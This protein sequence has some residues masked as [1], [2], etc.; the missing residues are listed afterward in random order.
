MDQIL[1]AEQGMAGSPR[2]RPSRRHRDRHIVHFLKSEMDFNAEGLAQR[3]NAIAEHLAK[4]SLNV[5][6]D[7]EDDLVETGFDCVVD[8][9][10]D[11]DLAVRPD[12][13]ELLDAAAVARAD[14]GC[15][16]HKR[17][18]HDGFCLRKMF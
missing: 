9:I 16:D 11:D 14:P 15:E 10:I 1:A 17:F 3:F 6:T 5:V 12:R 13:R 2:L 7:D 4:I 8:R 18:F